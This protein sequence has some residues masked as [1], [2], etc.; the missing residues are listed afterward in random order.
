MNCPNCGG[1]LDLKNKRCEY[2]STTF[3]DKE[4]GIEPKTESKKAVESPAQPQRPKTLTEQ[5]QEELRRQQENRP[6]Q[7]VDNDVLTGAAVM[8][9]MSF[10][11][12]VRGFFRDLKRTVG[13]ILLIILEAVF[14]FVMISGKVTQLL[15][16]E[17]EGFIAVN[18]VILIHALLAGLISRI[19]YLRAGTAIVAVVNFLAAAWTFAYPLLKTD[20]AGQTP[21]SVAILAVVEMVVLALSVL[22]CHLVYRRH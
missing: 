2:C 21:E 6:K 11:P 17:L 19:G 14:A 20:F 1:L 3:T 22:L 18:I 9:A 15:D 5:K 13:M 12:R 16:G 8:S 4:L 10:F 7:T